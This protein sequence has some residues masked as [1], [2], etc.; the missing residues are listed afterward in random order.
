M[1][2]ITVIMTAI[3]II[4]EFKPLKFEGFSRQT[5]FNAF[6]LSPQK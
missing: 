3:S 6:F 4:Q 1:A 5:S 2:K